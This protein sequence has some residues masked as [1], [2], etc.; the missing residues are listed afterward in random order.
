MIIPHSEISESTLRNIIKENILRTI[1]DIDF[2]IEHE[3]DK[4]RNQI[5]SGNIRIVY[6]QIKND[7]TLVSSDKFKK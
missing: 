5:Y 7:V 6:S 4:V 2:D 3:I 1:D